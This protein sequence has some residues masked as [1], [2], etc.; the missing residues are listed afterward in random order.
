M[1]DPAI[2]T[3]S[4][5]AADDDKRWMRRCL[6]DSLLHSKKEKRTEKLTTQIEEEAG[7]EFSHTLTQATPMTAGD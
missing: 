4:V 2:W 5:S 7:I 3:F 6:K 1:D